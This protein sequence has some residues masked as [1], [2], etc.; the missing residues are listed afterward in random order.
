[1]VGGLRDRTA[2]V[3]RNRSHLNGSLRA[4][5]RHQLEHEDF[6]LRSANLRQIKGTTAD[7]E[8][9]GCRT[10]KCLC[11]SHRDSFGGAGGRNTDQKVGIH[12]IGPDGT[13]EH[14]G[15]GD[16]SGLFRCVGSEQVG[17]GRLFVVE[18][19][20]QFGVIV[21]AHKAAVTLHPIR[22]RVGGAVLDGADRGREILGFVVQLLPQLLEAV[23][24]TGDTGLG[25]G[26]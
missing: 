1:M 5:K 19:R 10:G 18:Q 25:V 4:G 13:V 24:Q 23:L 21:L 11:T 3:G 17:G 12:Q 14:T 6:C 2:S 9:S 16:G 7:G 26:E 20:E 15:I 8:I 22:A